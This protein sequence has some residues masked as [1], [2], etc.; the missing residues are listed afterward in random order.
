MVLTATVD[1]TGVK[2]DGSAMIYGK[3]FIAYRKVGGVL[4]KVSESDIVPLTGEG[5]L[6][7]VACTFSTN[8]NVD[9]LVTVTGKASTT[10][11]WRLQVMMNEMRF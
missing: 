2:S 7:G 5:T 1:I 8:A 4:T 11:K 3:K 10:I 6:S 9:L